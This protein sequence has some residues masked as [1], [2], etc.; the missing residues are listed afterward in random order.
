MLTYGA[1]KRFED[2][3]TLRKSSYN[4]LASPFALKISSV[5][6]EVK[7]QNLSH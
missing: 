4:T 6:T 1:N 7:L 3:D 2:F 5:T